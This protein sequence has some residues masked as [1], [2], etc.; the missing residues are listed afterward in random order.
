MKK[1]FVLLALTFLGLASL[2]AQSAEKIS[3]ILKSQKITFGQASYLAAVGQGLVSDEDDF[4]KAFDALKANGEFSKK[5]QNDVISLKE[6]CNLCMK[7]AGIG[8]GLFYSITKSPRYAFKEL[9]AKQILPSY[10][11]PDFTLN[12]YEAMAILN[13]CLNLAEE[14]K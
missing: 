12:G 2:N 13:G 6:Y 9:Q 8:G 10:A 11:D 1:V 14:K 5:N 4:S 3:S 7:T